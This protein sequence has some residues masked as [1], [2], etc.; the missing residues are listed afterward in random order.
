MISTTKLYAGVHGRTII[1]HRIRCKLGLTVEE[2]IVLDFIYCQL[3]PGEE[4]AEESWK[5]IG[6]KVEDVNSI[7]KELNAKS[8]GAVTAWN[9]EFAVDDDFEYFW[10]TIFKK[11]GN[12]A[13]AKAKYE[14]SR[15][16]VDKD[17]LHARAQK[18]VD[19]RQD[20]PN[21]TKAAEVWLNPKKRHWEDLLP[22]DK[23]VNG[24]PEGV[25]RSTFPGL[26]TR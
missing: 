25:P 12:R 3:K 16:I 6:M 22:G 24:L 15:K 21:Y 9:Q 5:R 11:H 10:N 18:Y 4:A 20:F 7:L 26:K 13:D 2:Y 19:T 1:D 8:I 14:A 17:I 23:E